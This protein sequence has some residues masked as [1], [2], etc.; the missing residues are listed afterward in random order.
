MEYSLER[1]KKCMCTDGFVDYDS[2]DLSGIDEDM[3]P[4]L[5]ELNEKKIDKIFE[6]NFDIFSNLMHNV[7]ELMNGYRKFT[8]IGVMK[9]K[10]GFNIISNDDNELNLDF[11]QNGNILPPILKKNWRK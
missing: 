6:Y 4:I 8:M 3:I 11:Y 10:N 5:I 1:L 9:T 2:V 7:F